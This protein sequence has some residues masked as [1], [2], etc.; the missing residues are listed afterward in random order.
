MDTF[1][2]VL[3]VL[4]F[5]ASLVATVCMLVNRKHI[6]DQNTKIN[7]YRML[8]GEALVSADHV[9]E[10]QLR[11]AGRSAEQALSK[12][13]GINNFDLQI[14]PMLD[15]VIEATRQII[16]TELTAQQRH[17]LGLSITRDV[18][19]LSNVVENV[20]LMA[21]L[22][23]KRIEY[24]LDEM[25]VGGFVKHLYED[26]SS[27]DGVVYSSKDDGGCKLHLIEG[28]P[29]LQI[30]ADHMYLYRAVS[31][32]LKN[33]FTFSRKGDIFLGWFYHL[34]TSEVE[35][36]VEDNGIGIQPENLEKVF[37]V[38]YKETDTQGMG[39]GLSLTKELVENMGGKIILVS[40]PNIGTRVSLLFPMS[41]Y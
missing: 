8:I 29:T 25:V 20:L 3:C 21:R 19:Q 34:G 30:K 37:D 6:Q 22:D 39:I 1:I 36:F 2:I 15:S 33:A 4:I 18:K 32:L 13:N 23:S 28:R 31:E 38:F 35:I 40:H 5:A 27:Q 9:N 11:L 26:F 41:S 10:E 17:E 7:A 14:R 16:N 12:G 24:S